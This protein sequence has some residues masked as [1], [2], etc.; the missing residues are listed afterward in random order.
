MNK[1]LLLKI[2]LFLTIG[3]VIIWVIPFNSTIEFSEDIEEN[4][5]EM[6]D[7]NL[8]I[9]PI[10]SDRCFACHGPDVN[11]READLR[12]DVEADALDLIG[13]NKDHYAIV[14]GNPLKSGVYQRIVSEEADLK[15]PP[16]ESNL[17][18]NETE[19]ALITRWIEQG[20]KYKPHWSFIP[21][22]K[23]N[24]PT[25]DDKA[26]SWAENEIDHFVYD[27]MLTKGLAP[28]EKAGRETLIR[29]LSFDL[30]GLPPSMEDVEDFL[31]DNSKEAYLKL[32]DKY[33][34]SPHYGERLA[35]KW[36]DLARYADSNG[37][38]DDGMRNMW[39]WRDWVINAF[40]ENLPYD[41]FILWQL[42][43]DL[44]PNPT[45]DQILAT[46][47]NR[48]HPQSQEGGI[49]PEEYRVEY[50]AD[51]ANT[52]GKA[53]LGLS[54]ECARCHD[55]K[56]DPIS[57]KEYF[58]LY[59][60]F[61]NI[62]ET[63][64]VPYVGDASPT[65]ILKDDAEIEKKIAYIN[66]EIRVKETA[67][68]SDKSQALESFQNWLSN[69]NTKTISQLPIKG[70]IGHYPLDKPFD[71]KFKNLADKSKPA[72]MVVIQKDKEI[73]TVPGK[74]E[75]GIQ[76]V[77]DSYVDLGPNIAYFE[78]SDPFTIS[79]WYKALAD[80]L[81]GPI[82]SKTGGFANGFRG[83]ELLIT[84]DGHLT[85]LMSHTWPANAIEIHTKERV[86]VGEWVHLTM[87]YDGSS[88]ASGLQIYI[89][90]KPLL[91]NVITDHLK[92]SILAYGKEKRGIGHPGNLQI[93]KRGTSF[94]ETLDQSLVDEIR[95]F[96]RELTTIEAERLAG[97][98]DPIM[99]NINEGNHEALQDYYFSVVNQQYKNQVNSLNQLRK[100]EN[101]LVSAQP[102]VMVMRERS[103]ERETFILDRGV[104]DAPT[105]Q[106]FPETP[107]VLLDFPE[108]LPKNR[109][110]LAKWLLHEKNPLTARVVVNQYW[111]LIFGRGIVA[112]P[113]DFGNQGAFPSHPELLDWLAVNFIE[114]GWDL[115]QLMKLMVSSATYQQSSILKKDARE[116]DP[117][118]IWLSRANAS[119]L[120]AEMV[121]D[122]ALASSGLLV[123]KTGGE[124]VKPYQP[125]GLWRELTS[126]YAI[127]Y[128]EDTG[129]NLYR[130][131]L[132]TIWKRSAPPPS[133]INFDASDKYVCIIKRQNTNTPLQALVLMNDPQYI[134]ASRVLAEKMLKVGGEEISA[135]LK[136][137]FRAITSRNPE[138]NELKILEE[139]YQNELNE[140][141]RAPH[142]ADSLLQVGEFA[143]DVSLPKEKLAAFTLVN[144][145]LMNY[146]EA[147]YKR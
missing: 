67:I 5:P 146:D 115:K 20:A 60:F 28:S 142:E 112:T 62:N 68:D 113:D 40:N 122:Q 29:R 135:Q 9:K 78:R 131:S 118:N 143:R 132:Y 126:E 134:E 70:Q 55:H 147:I 21:P 123:R 58:Q 97:E 133:M 87:T 41:D 109:L 12:L 33:L 56:Y 39:P 2:A 51:R 99:R 96:D 110:G 38:Q 107:K 11:K 83:Y 95:I 27:K 34:E 49:I 145:T 85:G 140:F 3:L 73:L 94:A 90:G 36:L 91:V 18:L 102:E 129:D 119:R 65:L 111:E 4:L 105:E 37:Y 141:Q 139:L 137:G 30:T 77:G 72:D 10:L 57:Q 59:A 23:I 63:G 35:S 88:K 106:V 81:N 98:P 26:L 1:G 44:L 120:P 121:R 66:E 128:I 114:S 45:Y 117:A 125:K 14:P 13:E 43:G 92:Q 64:Q 80:S 89:N 103:E 124:S 138:P 69:S 25:L 82:F 22:Q 47:F 130:R 136:Y 86:P 42:A 84:E 7:F 50:V 74:F 6:V 16:I 53:F 76:L 17:K 100:K 15:M 116:K 79:L 32:V 46:G 71:N 19:I 108:E 144:S 93:G 127:E 61:N 8:H 52:L 101:E 75:N 24:T 48:N 104:Y 54:I 31:K